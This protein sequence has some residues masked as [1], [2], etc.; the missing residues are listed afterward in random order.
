SLTLMFANRIN[1]NTH[2]ISYALQQYNKTL[3]AEASTLPE[4]EKIITIDPRKRKGVLPQLQDIV[5]Q[6]SQALHIDSPIQLDSP[7]HQQATNGSMTLKNTLRVL[8]SSASK[9]SIIAD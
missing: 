5:N 3:G 4:I 7:T 9:D 8:L 6:V 2:A 1:V